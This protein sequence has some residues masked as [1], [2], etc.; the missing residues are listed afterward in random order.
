MELNFNIFKKDKKKDVF[1]SK[2]YTMRFEEREKLRIHSKKA[3]TGREKPNPL[4]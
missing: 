2:Y 4:H 1:K 3:H